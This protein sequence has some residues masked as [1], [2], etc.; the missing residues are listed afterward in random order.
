MGELD[1]HAGVPIVVRQ[2]TQVAFLV[3]LVALVLA[4]VANLGR[5]MAPDDLLGYL[6]IGATSFVGLMN[7]RWLETVRRHPMIAL[8]DALLVAS[9]VAFDGVDS[10]LLLAALTTA[11][12]IGLWV[13]PRAGVI[14]VLP[15]V[16]LYL[17]GASQHPIEV[18]QI[19]I[20]VVVLPFVFVTLWLLGATV[21][22]AVH[23]EARAQLVVRDA[24]ATAAA[25]EERSRVARELHDSL[26]KTLQGITLSAVALPHLLE[27]DGQGAAQVAEQLR[28]MGSTAVAQVRGLMN[29][30]RTPA[31][32]AS[33]HESLEQLA[34]SWTASTG[35]VVD[36]DLAPVGTRNEAVKYELLTVAGECLD[37]IAR[38]AGPCR[39]TMS[40]SAEGEELVLEVCDD[41]KG[42]DPDRVS[43][44]A[45]AGHHG[46]AGLHERMA[47]IGGRATWHSAPGAGTRVAFRVHR[48]GLVER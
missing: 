4:M 2:L 17:L 3:R 39:T 47:R 10:P 31:T 28:D 14:V 32:T 20:L 7:T 18:S 43:A 34:A 25:S 30:L 24:V 5:S 46:L 13:D 27:R 16:L 40:L 22:R 41:G 12:L 15:L 1:R 8:V 35:R 48:E 11:L 19:F 36:L 9:A 6:V 37:N 33:L 23:R 26:A 21:S 45:R 44:A 42:A 38:H 29:D